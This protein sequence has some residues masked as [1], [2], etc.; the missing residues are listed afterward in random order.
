M[1]DFTRTDE[2]PHDR[3]TRIGDAMTIAM[4]GHPEVREGDR[5]I[6]FLDS[7]ERGGIVLHGYT[8][9]TEAM[10][11]LLAHIEVLFKANGMEMRFVPLDAMGQG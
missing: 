5:A 6:I 2:Q 1:S 7:K 10:A 4:D 8:D 11:D 3:L 9:G